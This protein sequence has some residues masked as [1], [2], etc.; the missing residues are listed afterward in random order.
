LLGVGSKP[1][2]LRVWIERAA[3][4]TSLNPA[5]GSRLLAALCMPSTNNQLLFA[6]FFSL[7]STAEAQKSSSIGSLCLREMIGKKKAEKRRKKFRKK[8]EKLGKNRE[9]LGGWRD[10]GEWRSGD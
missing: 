6:I 10:C 3:S 7:D 2:E 9:S 8:S 1:R 5:H 4:L